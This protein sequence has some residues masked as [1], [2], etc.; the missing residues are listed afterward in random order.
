MGKT[1]IWS[2]LRTGRRRGGVGVQDAQGQ[3][4]LGVEEAWA[5][6][7]GGTRCGGTKMGGSSGVDGSE[8]ERVDAGRGDDALHTP[9]V[10][11]GI[12]A[13]EG[14]ACVVELAGTGRQGDSVW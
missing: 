6:R 3:W 8:L 1:F 7:C 12:V 10:V 2:V 14:T 5:A 13:I 4:A 11:S 9:Y